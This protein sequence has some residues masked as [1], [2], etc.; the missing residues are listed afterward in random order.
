[1]SSKASN[2]IDLKNEMKGFN[3]QKEYLL[4]KNGVTH[5]SFK[6][7]TLAAFSSVLLP[8]YPLGITGRFLFREIDAA[9]YARCST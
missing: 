8:S 1:M 7:E 6:I 2:G 5:K 3:S 9:L 4:Q